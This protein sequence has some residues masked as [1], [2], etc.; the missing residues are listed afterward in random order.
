MRKE[1][2]FVRRRS[3]QLAATPPAIPPGP[4]M[5]GSH[6]TDRFDFDFARRQRSVTAEALLVL[7]DLQVEDGV[8]E[9]A[10]DGGEFSNGFADDQV[11]NAV[12]QKNF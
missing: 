1:S 11:T 10:L 8:V 12:V 5:S 6:E 7:A 9:A 2:V 3:L 4:G